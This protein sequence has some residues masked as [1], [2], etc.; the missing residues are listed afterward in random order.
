MVT[1]GEDMDWADR[2]L[3]LIRIA[4]SVEIKLGEANDFISGF[5]EDFQTIKRTLMSR[6]VICT[7]NSFSKKFIPL[8]LL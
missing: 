4:A 2:V 8:I 1:T 7:H 6:E 5:V 3:A